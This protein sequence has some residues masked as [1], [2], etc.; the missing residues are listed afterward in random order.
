MAKPRANAPYDPQGK[1]SML[2]VGDELNL[3]PQ[4]FPYFD[5]KGNLQWSLGLTNKTESELTAVENAIKSA[6]TQEQKDD[7]MNEF[8]SISFSTFFNIY[9]VPTP[10]GS[11]K[12]QIEAPAILAIL[13]SIPK[14]ANTE[15]L[16]AQAWSTAIAQINVQN[17]SNPRT[18]IVVSDAIIALSKNNKPYLR[19]S[20]IDL[21]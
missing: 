7:L 11:I 14:T 10:E 16:Y 18:K 20:K 15:E 1:G 8:K 2:K 9:P 17:P 3:T 5:A 19:A 21:A 4:I 13:R 12:L 6:T